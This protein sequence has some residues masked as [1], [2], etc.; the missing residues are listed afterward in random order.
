MGFLIA[1]AQGKD[2]RAS[3]AD[4]SK[5]VQDSMPGTKGI[6]TAMRKPGVGYLY[7]QYTEE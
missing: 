5:A 2:Y 7:I 4:K 1:V 3:T 6:S